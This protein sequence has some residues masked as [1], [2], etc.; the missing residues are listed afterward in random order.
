MQMGT[1]ALRGHRPRLPVGFPTQGG[2]RPPPGVVL[3][4]L[5]EA[6]QQNCDGRGTHRQP[7]LAEGGWALMLQRH[8]LLQTGPHEL[9]Q[10]DQA[11]GATRPRGHIPKGMPTPQTDG[12]ASQA[13]SLK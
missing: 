5:G 3:V 12:Q 9:S 8:L 4:G 2:G 13:D 6:T 1:E 7:W 11:T 10:W